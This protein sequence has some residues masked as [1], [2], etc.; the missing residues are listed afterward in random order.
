MVKHSQHWVVSGLLFLTLKD[1]TQTLDHRNARR[2]CWGK[3]SEAMS[4]DASGEVGNRPSLCFQRSSEADQSKNPS[5]HP[6]ALLN[7]EV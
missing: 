1:R 4:V 3:P 7:T 6:P 5:L 2:S